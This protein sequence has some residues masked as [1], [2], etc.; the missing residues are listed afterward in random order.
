[1]VVCQE[2]LKKAEPSIAE[3]ASH[4]KIP[5]ANAALGS[6][7]QLAKTEYQGLGAS[8]QVAKG[9]NLVANLRQVMHTKYPLTHS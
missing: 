6:A 9:P 4:S 7:Y 3:L 1:M 2:T 8:D 5:L